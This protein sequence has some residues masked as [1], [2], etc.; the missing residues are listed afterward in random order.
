MSGFTSH[1]QMFKYL[2]NL[3]N[4]GTISLKLIFHGIEYDEKFNYNPEKDI[5]TANSSQNPNEEFGSDGKTLAD[6]IANDYIS[7]KVDFNK[8]N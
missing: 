6:Y 4:E 5:L 8:I 3:Y 1:K 7:L 2:V